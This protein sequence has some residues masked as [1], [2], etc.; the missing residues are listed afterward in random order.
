MRMEAHR[1]SVSRAA[2]GPTLRAAGTPHTLVPMAAGDCSLSTGSQA[3]QCPGSA[4]V[5]LLQPAEGPQP[6]AQGDFREAKQKRL[7]DRAEE[8]RWRR[9][10][11]NQLG[12]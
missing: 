4:N 3:S 6:S 12:G 1:G 7:E 10:A 11:G 5:F 2:G 9:D 8:P